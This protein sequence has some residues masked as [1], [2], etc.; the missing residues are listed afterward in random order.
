M[1]LGEKTAGMENGDFQNGPFLI[2][3]CFPVPADEAYF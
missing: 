1:Y 2:I 3:S